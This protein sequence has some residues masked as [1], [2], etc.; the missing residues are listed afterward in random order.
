MW[1]SPMTV[2]DIAENIDTI[3]NLG[4]AGVTDAAAPRM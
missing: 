2:E 1:R 3:L 4:D